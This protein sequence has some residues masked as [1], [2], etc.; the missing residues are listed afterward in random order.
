MSIYGRRSGNSFWD[1]QDEI[2]KTAYVC[3]VILVVNAIVF[4]I[5]SLFYEQLYELGDLSV[6]NVLVNKEYYRLIT[7][8]FL[9]GGIDHLVGNMIILFVLGA[10]LERYTGHIVFFI[11]YMITGI[12]GNLLTIVFEVR[13]GLSWNSIGASGAIMGLIGFLLVWFV[14]SGGRY[15]GDSY[16]LGRLF[17][18]AIYVYQAIR[19]QEGIN[20]IAHLGGFTAGFFFG[21]INIIILKNNKEMEGLT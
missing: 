16:T 3:I 1:R 8:M 9:H 17:I 20:N 7:S 10:I 12:C 4:I 11:L 13:N 21:L 2:Y 14:A 15:L 5:S 19:Y 6:T 18:L